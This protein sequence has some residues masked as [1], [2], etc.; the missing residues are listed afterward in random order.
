MFCP[1]TKFDGI[2]CVEGCFFLTLADVC[3]AAGEEIDEMTDDIS[4]FA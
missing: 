4:L 2:R 1:L 3:S